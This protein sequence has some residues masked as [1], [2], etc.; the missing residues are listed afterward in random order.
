MMSEI[1]LNF[2]FLSLSNGANV[3]GARLFLHSR[4]ESVTAGFV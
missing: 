4:F 2:L 1:D 3:T